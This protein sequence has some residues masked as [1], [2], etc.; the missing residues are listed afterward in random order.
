MNTTTYRERWNLDSLFNGKGNSPEL[1]KLIAQTNTQIRGLSEIINTLYSKSLPIE[2]VLKKH[3]I[4]FGLVQL[5]LSQMSSFVTCLLAESPKDQKALMLRGKTASLQAEYSTTLIRFQQFLAEIDIV[6]WNT[7]M[8]DEQFADYQFILNEWRSQANSPL[9]TESESLLSDLKVDGYHAWGDLYRSIVNNLSVPIEINGMR[10]E[11]SIAQATNLRSHPDRDIRQ[12]AAQALQDLWLSQQ[13][14]MAQILNHL[15]GFR[16]KADKIKGIQNGLEK[17]L[18]D[19]RIQ[20]ETLTAMWQ[21]VSE[22]KNSFASYLTHKASSNKMSFHDFW[23]PFNHEKASMEYSQA[24]EFLLDQFHQFGPELEKF[25]RTAFENGWIECANTSGKGSVAFCAGFP[26][27]GESRV[28]LTFDGSMTSLLTLTHELGHAFHNHAM[29]GTAPLNRK[30]GMTTAESA[31]T[32]CEMIVLDAAIKKAEKPKEK[33]MLLD[34]KIKRSVMNFMNLHGRF[35]FEE[36]LY[37][38]RKQGILSAERINELMEEALNEG[39]AGSIKDLPMHY[40]ISTP[41]FYIT[42]SPFY[43]FPYTFGYLFSV[44][45]YAKAREQGSGFEQQYLAL[46]RDTGKLTVEELAMKHLGVD[47]TQKDFWEKGMALCIEDVEEFIK[48]SELESV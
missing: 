18:Q 1:F 29:K 23:A 10:E 45:I 8:D 48:L 14:T 17:P 28:F 39:Y 4:N 21:V 38:E 36:R 46:L 40:W 5:S 27:T 9:S 43:N 6:Q 13:D 30:Y 34:E 25:V 24:A 2:K 41:H 37:E 47:I 20:K 11:Y 3:L 22:N 32:F 26:M 42:S 15:T 19:N 44:S 12:Q 33:L 35:L 16:L 31:S 7:L